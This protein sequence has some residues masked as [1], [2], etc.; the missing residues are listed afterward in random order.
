M[1][2]IEPTRRQV[3]IAMALAGLASPTHSAPAADDGERIAL[4]L[5][6][7][8][9]ELARLAA[10]QRPIPP[11]LLALG[12][13]NWPEAFIEH[14]DDIELVFERRPGRP[15]MHLDELL[16]L[17]RNVLA[18]RRG[19]QAPYCSLDPQPE[20]MRALAKLSGQRID[21]AEPAAVQRHAQ[22][23]ERAWNAK[24]QQ[25]V[26]GGSA[27]PRDSLSAHRCIDADYDMKKHSQG[28]EPLARVPSLIDRLL[29]APG[30]ASSGASMARFW[31]RIADAQRQP[32]FSVDGAA[33]AIDRLD[34]A[35]F[36]ERQVTSADGHTRDAGGGNDPVMVAMAADLSRYMTAHPAQGSYAALDQ[37]YRLLA[38]LQAVDFR[39]P[40]DAA[41]LPLLAQRQ[42][43][44][45]QRPM[46]PELPGLVNHR[47]VRS[48]TKQGNVTTTSLRLP[49]VI[50]GGDLAMTIRRENI[51]RA[52]RPLAALRRL[53]PRP[54]LQ[55]PG[56]AEPVYRV[57]R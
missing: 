43:E 41:R 42:R 29:A 17:M 36:T 15:A 10:A 9:R 31:F 30:S 37:S 38:L 18:R 55:G 19:G 28:K 27:V 45:A 3:V 57:F 13:G 34:V 33:V 26:I 49:I 6:A 44:L 4:S 24:G 53:P 48:E 47:L 50:G 51:Q 40:L 16:V 2:P 32:S 56:P 8:E 46:P 22:A 1:F 52:A 20:S 39:R 21:I 25:V 7:L 23:I 11:D 5:R 54:R 12:G 14:D 35:I